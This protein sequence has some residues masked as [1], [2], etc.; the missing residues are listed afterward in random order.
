MAE[1]A[2]GLASPKGGVSLKQLVEAVLEDRSTAE[3]FLFRV[4]CGCCGGEC[5]NKPR[6]F[7][8]AGAA[9]EDLNQRIIFDALYQQEHL[10]ARQFAIRAAAEQMN[11]CPICRRLVCN[12]CFLIC[13]ELD[14]CR[15][16][17]RRLGQTGLS[18]LPE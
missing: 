13:G 3:V 4:Q 11:Q 9:P 2:R 15:E 17:A 16:C 18:V 6:R 8:R 10:Q 7:S 1:T 5:G 14:M 12:G